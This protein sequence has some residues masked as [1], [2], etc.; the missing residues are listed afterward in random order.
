MLLLQPTCSTGLLL[1]QQTSVALSSMRSP[2]SPKHFSTTFL[3][4]FYWFMYE[5]YA[6]FV[7]S[8]CV[9]GILLRCWLALLLCC[10]CRCCCWIST[11]SSASSHASVISHLRNDTGVRWKA[12]ESPNSSTN[13]SRAVMPKYKYTKFTKYMVTLYV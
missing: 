2:L 13:T 1:S 3:Q 8:C 12:G 7:F 10:C 5:R 9:A 11:H 6:F 4:A